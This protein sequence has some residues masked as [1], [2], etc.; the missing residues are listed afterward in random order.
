MEPTNANYSSHIES[1]NRQP[2]NEP[3]KIFDDQ[4]TTLVSNINQD[5]NIKPISTPFTHLNRE[6]N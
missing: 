1:T 3:M 6:K 5:L 4:K 2:F